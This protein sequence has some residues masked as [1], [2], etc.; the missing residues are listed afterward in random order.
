MKRIVTFA[1]LA[2]FAVALPWAAVSQQ[3][4]ESLMLSVQVQA[5]D[6]PAVEDRLPSNPYV[7]TEQP[8]VGS[9]ST[10]VVTLPHESDLDLPF[11]YFV[12]GQHA[13]SILHW[14]ENMV[15]WKVDATI[16]KKQGIH[17]DI[18]IEPNLAESWEVSADGREVT[19]HLR[20]GVKWSDGAEFTTE[21]IEFTVEGKQL[22]MLQTRTGKR[23]GPAAV[24]N[25]R[26][27]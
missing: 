20:Q 4:S 15:Q 26:P 3:Y 2:A 10:T 8:E 25:D 1:V 14:G 11:N 6:L 17:P 23:T 16:G 13:R 21:D 24:N 18:S 7:N 12:T 27:E 5:G 22:F 19:F 9:Y